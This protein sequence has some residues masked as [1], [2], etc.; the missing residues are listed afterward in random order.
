MYKTCHLVESLQWK[1]A[2]KEYSFGNCEG[3][4]ITRALTPFRNLVPPVIFQ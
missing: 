2:R 1:G 3:H 4:Q